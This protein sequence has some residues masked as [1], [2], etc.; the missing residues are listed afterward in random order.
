MNM[1]GNVDILISNEIE[2]I[3]SG[4]FKFGQVIKEKGSGLVAEGRI[5][6]IW[7]IKKIEVYWNTGRYSMV[8]PEKITR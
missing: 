3:Y 5:Y 2:N 8:S 6:S 4:N 1:S 7:D